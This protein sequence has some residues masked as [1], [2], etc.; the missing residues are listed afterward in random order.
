MKQ[1]LLLLILICCHLLPATA[2]KNAPK[3]MD[4]SKKAVVLITT[5][6][7]DGAKLTSGTGFYVSETG[8]V[9]A[10][11]DLFK[12]AEKATITDVDGKTYPVT[13]IVGA[14]ELYDV[15]KVKSEAPK[16]VQFLPIASDPLVVG[17]AAYLL[18]YTTAK[19]LNFG[20]GTI[21]EV[22]KLKD[23]YSYYKL[24]IPLED[25]QVNAPILNA[26][27]QVFGLAQ[28]DASGKK[29]VSYAVSA[30]YTNSLSVA[31]TDF[32]NTVYNN[33]GIKKAWP[34]DEEQAQVALFLKG[35]TQDAK[36][37]LETLNDFIATFPNSA[38]GYLN[39]AS[40][41]AGRRA[42]LAST[43]AEQANYLN[44]ALD[45]IK[46]AS[47]FSDKK[48]DVYYNQ[49]KLIY[50]VAAGDTTLTDPAWSVQAA[51]ETIQKAIQ[52]EDLP[53]YHQLAGDIHFF[54]KEYEQAY[55]EYM[56]VN[57]SDLASPTSFYWAAKAKENVTGFN[58]GDII[59]LL[60]GAIE[61]SG[62]PL[63]PE[64]GQYILERI[65]WKLRL[66]QYAEAIADYDL[67]YKAMNGDVTSNFYYYREQA[68]FRSDDL[69]GALADIKEAI[70]LS[71]DIPDYR[72]EEASVYVR[73]KNYNDALTSIDNA[74]KVAPDFAACYRL[75][76][77]CYVR[78]EKKAEA[79]EA[80]NKAKELGDP[81]AERLIKEHCK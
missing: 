63:T 74:L 53:V 2:Q 76:G 5:Y 7:K 72:A 65:D 1:T 80:L 48:G 21:T 45:D 62:L 8:D 46:T 73:M 6:G 70:R 29:D 20:Q 22:S 79:C 24:S 56:V 44:K 64:A 47:K 42:E 3:W 13:A 57:N 31:A 9:L 37:Y 77:I 17:T 10:A 39:R 81:L 40:H 36:S 69:E 60:D 78:M 51:L 61:K 75:K 23:P 55:N 4:K 66:S 30:A 15:I 35:S 41:Y 28:A 58:I 32:L 59:A 25:G 43:P 16:K 38:D 12:G 49:A 19:T 68:K 54:L 26:E 14:D 71:P 27:G 34:A 33:I 67:Y 11:Y 52:E 18:P 50:N